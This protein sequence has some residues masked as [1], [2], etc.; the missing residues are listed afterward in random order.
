VDINTLLNQ[1]ITKPTLLLLDEGYLYAPAAASEASE[2][3]SRDLVNFIYQTRKLDVNVFWSF[4]YQKDTSKPIREK[5]SHFCIAERFSWGFRYT[6]LKRHFVIGLGLDDTGL[7][8]EKVI[9]LPL[10]WCRDTLWPLFN[11][12]EVISI[13]TVRKQRQK[14]KEAQRA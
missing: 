6:I 10:A 3:T 14:Y 13:Q 12:K 4:Q 11:T 9:N 7:K 2:I 8:V 1:D 5:A